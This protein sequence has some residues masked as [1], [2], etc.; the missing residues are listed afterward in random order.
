M[1]REAKYGLTYHTFVYEGERTPDLMRQQEATRLEIFAPQI[2]S[3]RSTPAKRSLSSNAPRRCA[4][5]E[6][7]PLWLALNHRQA[8]HIA[9]GRAGGTGPS[10]RHGRGPDERSAERLHRSFRTGRQRLRFFVRCVGQDLRARLPAETAHARARL[11]F[12]PDTIPGDTIDGESGRGQNAMIATTD[13][14]V[15]RLGQY[16]GRWVDRD[17]RRGAGTRAL[18]AFDKPL[19]TVE[20]TKNR[21][22]VALKE[23]FPVMFGDQWERARDIFYERFRG[24]HLEHVTVMPGAAEALLASGAWPRGVVS[25]KAGK[26]LRAE[27]RQLQWTAHF[28]AVVGAGDARADKPDPAPILMALE[29]L[30]LSGRSGRLV[31]GR[32]RA[33]HGRR[34]CRGRNGRSC[35]RC[36]A[37]DGVLERAAPDLHLQSAHDLAGWKQK[38]GLERGEPDS[39]RRS[40]VHARDPPGQQ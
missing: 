23:S 40:A 14:S 13:C 24:D 30:G 35:R 26:F 39:F 29:Q 25:N 7:L 6:I 33:R 37:H 2:L 3:R 34:S 20:D 28:G 9:V 22:R 10:R 19:W 38:P 8:E 11:T 27:V 12:S 17:L 31:S 32:H 1:I 21:V 5:S 4:E 36:V 18:G 15:I 16:A